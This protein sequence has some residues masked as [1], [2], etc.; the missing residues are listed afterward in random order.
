M[1]VL[2]THQAC[3]L[4]LTYYQYTRHARNHLS[5]R[6]IW[7]IGGNDRGVKDRQRPNHYDKSVVLCA[8]K[9]LTFETFLVE[10]YKL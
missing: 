8:I 7:M 4:V 6:E 3:V 5:Q 10:F 1:L 2:S 9:T